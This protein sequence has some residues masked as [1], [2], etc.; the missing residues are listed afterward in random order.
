MENWSQDVPKNADFYSNQNQEF[1]IRVLKEFN[2]KTSLPVVFLPCASV[3]PISKSRTHCYLSK[4]TRNEK[5]ERIILSEPQSIIPYSLEQFCPNYDYPPGQLHAGDRWQMVR[6]VGIFL[7]FLWENNEKRE[8]IYYIG[9]KHHLNVLN[10]ANNIM[11]HFKIISIIP[12]RGI[13]DYASAA[14]TFIKTIENLEG[15]L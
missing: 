4:I 13:R 7:H 11:K 1:Y 15:V 2:F 6:R 5:L 14:E 9:A 3:K 8:R 12:E 10:D